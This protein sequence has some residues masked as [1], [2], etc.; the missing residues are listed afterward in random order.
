MGFGIVEDRPTPPEVYNWRIYVFAIVASFG[1]LTFGYDGSFFGTTLA[2]ASFQ[3][4]FGF[5]EM[6]AGARTSN[7]ANITSCYLAAGFFG[8]LFAWPSSESLGRVR[9]MQ[10]TSSIFLIGVVLMTATTSSLSMMYGGRALTGF[11]VGALTGIIPSYIAEVAPP[12]IRGQLTGSLVGFWVNYGINQNMEVGSTVTFRIPI[13]LQFIPGGLLALGTLIL[14]ESPALLYRTGKKE[15]AIKN[16][17]YL[18]QLPAEHQYMLEEVGMIEARLAEET[19]LSGGR[20]G[21]LALLR[22]AGTELKN[23]SIRYRLYVTVGMFLFQNWS[24]SICINY[25]S[26]TLFKALDITDVA[27]YTGIY[28]VCRSAAAIAFYAYVVDYTGRRKPW[29]LSA[30]A[31]SLCLLYIGIYTTISPSTAPHSPSSQA[32]G[33]GGIA[34]V[35][36]YGI[37]W[38]FGGNGLPWIVAAEMYPQRIRPITGAFAASLQWLFSFVLTL[39]FPYMIDSRV[40]SN[41]TFFFF[42]ALCAATAVFTYIWVPE[43]KAVPIECMEALFSGRMRH[44]AWRSK[45]LFPPH[46]IPP[47]PEDIA[48]GQAAYIKAH[49]NRTDS[50]NYSGDSKI[51][52]EEIEEA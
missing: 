25:Y 36:L 32:A 49:T 16:L 28:G 3:E 45:K 11:G 10:V 23:R 22:G 6:S 5:T 20:T 37:F 17:C 1:A 43:T 21:W 31:C 39:A 24:G 9:A 29:L 50:Q 18:R 47:L 14:R 48:A 33:R 26:P 12:A 35:M 19:K 7:T 8:A 38:S 30:S 2:R 27:L 4:S 44:G 15:R 52:L 34:M 51:E 40:G 41:G 46:G 42:S 13:A